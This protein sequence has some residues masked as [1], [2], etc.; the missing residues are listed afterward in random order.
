[1]SAASTSSTETA[2]SE[3]VAPESNTGENMAS[4]QICSYW[5]AML[6]L[7]MGAIIF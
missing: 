5:Y 6:V 7:G 1:M 2:V 3:S 4:K